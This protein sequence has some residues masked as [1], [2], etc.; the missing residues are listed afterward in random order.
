MYSDRSGLILAF[1]GCDIKVR[2][3]VIANKQQLKSSNNSYDWLGSG[4]YFWENSPARALDFTEELK[5]STKKRVQ[6]IETPAVLGAIIDLKHCLDLTEFKNLQILKSGYDTLKEVLDTQ[7]LEL[8]ENKDI[9]KSKDLLMRHLDCAV[10][11]TIHANNEPT[12]RYDSVRG[13]FVEGD[14]AYPKAGF[15]E[16][17]HIQICVRNPNCIKGYFLPRELVK[18]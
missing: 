12:N 11:E 3:N 10:I 5:A 2:D 8:P 13:I 15:K 1:H 17:N 6:K 16:K 7:G 9:G 4:I 18:F 14:P